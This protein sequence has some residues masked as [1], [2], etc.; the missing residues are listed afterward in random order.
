MNVEH[1]LLNLRIY[2]SNRSILLKNYCVRT[3]CNLFPSN[4]VMI[5]SSNKNLPHTKVFQ[6]QSNRNQ[7]TLCLPL[8]L[9]S[10]LSLI[11]KV[12]KPPLTSVLLNIK[13]PLTTVNRYLCSSLR[14]VSPDDGARRIVNRLAGN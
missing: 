13:Y 5:C 7:P 1:N 14:D 6:S 12:I 4:L 10:V 11:N 3:L 8:Q 2:Y 9:N